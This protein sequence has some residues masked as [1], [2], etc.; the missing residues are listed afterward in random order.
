MKQ[1]IISA[2]KGQTIHQ[3]EHA[4]LTS[5]PG[6]KKYYFSAKAPLKNK[7]GK[8]IG[9]AGAAFDA[10]HFI[11]EIRDLKKA[12][13]SQSAQT[14][15]Q[16][17][18]LEQNRQ[19]IFELFHDLLSPYQGMLFELE[20]IQKK[21]GESTI[22]QVTSTI[23]C[24]IDNINNALSYLNETDNDGSEDISLKELLSAIKSTYKLK[25]KQKGLS[26][27]TSL[28]KN[29][30]IQVN[31]NAFLLRKIIE[32]IVNNSIKYTEQGVVKLEIRTKKQMLICKISD[33]GI[34]IEP[35]YHETIFKEF[36]Q[37]KTSNHITSGIGLGL[38]SV[39]KML[40]KLKGEIL[41]KSALGQGTTMT[42]TMPFALP[43]NRNDE[44]IYQP[45]IEARLTNKNN[46]SQENYIASILV[47]D[48]DL[49]TASALKAQV[50]SQVKPK[51]IT[52]DLAHSLHEA[53]EKI[54]NNRYDMVLTDLNL[55]DEKGYVLRKN[56]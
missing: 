36:S 3:I 42:I 25:A 18:T 1:Q 26:I 37:I 21:T 55:N 16:R 5:D 32:N 38:A 53:M 48:D 27:R 17:S 39:K 45:S 50:K 24:M 29:S 22:N 41:V 19:S 46:L 54:K 31:V 30:T 10:S 12:L 49:V 43:D 56:H 52:V 51:P 14:K 40:S 44:I 33:T 2:T 47:V 7:H 13:Q 20:T 8:I 15:E 34:G 11:K 35:K 4:K 6:K 9:M 28:G 23:H